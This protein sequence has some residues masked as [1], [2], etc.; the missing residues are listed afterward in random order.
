MAEIVYREV[1]KEAGFSAIRKTRFNVRTTPRTYGW[2]NV[3]ATI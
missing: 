2:L 1:Y 3:I